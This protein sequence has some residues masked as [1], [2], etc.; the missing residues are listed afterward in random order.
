MKRK[1]IDDK[2]RIM[3][4]LMMQRAREMAKFTGLS[5]KFCMGIVVREYERKA[6]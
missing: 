2:A 3:A 1:T 5:V 4:A 6:A